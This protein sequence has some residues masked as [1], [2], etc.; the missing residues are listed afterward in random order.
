MS[1]ESQF[2]TKPLEIIPQT[3]SGISILM[4]KPDVLTMPLIST[5]AAQDILLGLGD[6]LSGKIF[7]DFYQS[8]HFS[9]TAQWALDRRGKPPVKEE[10]NRSQLV[11]GLESLR[12]RYSLV[13]GEINLTTFIY[14]TL[15]ATQFHVL[16]EVE[17]NFTES[18]IRKLYTNLNPPDPIYGEA[19]KQT[20][21][22]A[23]Q[24]GPLKFIFLQG[25][26]EHK[27]LDVMK[28]ILRKTLRN[29][30]SDV[31]N[32]AKN[33]IHVPD[34][35]EAELTLGILKEYFKQIQS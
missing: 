28:D 19:W 23:L 6:A 34:E 16:G 1:I 14:D 29:Y 15:G 12:A 33:I 3:V 31:G 30:G 20:V 2:T 10:L 22:D 25:Q 21:I 18:W 11:M 8:S 9:R 5:E 7:S 13:P 4:L 32:L 24:E 35:N 17:C 27:F 26:L